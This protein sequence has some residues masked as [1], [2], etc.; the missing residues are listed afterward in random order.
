VSLGGADPG[1]PDRRPKPLDDNDK[2][3]LIDYVRRSGGS[4][5]RTSATA[6]P[7]ST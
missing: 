1:D 7:S 2:L 3:Q 5:A 6:S 4:T